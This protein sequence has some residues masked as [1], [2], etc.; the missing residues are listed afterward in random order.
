MLRDL[1]AGKRLE[2]DV[3]VAMVIELSEWLRVDV[4]KLPAVYAATALLD[5]AHSDA[6]ATGSRRGCDA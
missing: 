1:E 3:L 2:L 4:P 6:A 5:P